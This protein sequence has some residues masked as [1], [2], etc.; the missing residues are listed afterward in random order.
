LENVDYPF[1]PPK[2]NGIKD[3]KDLIGK[4]IA[5]SFP[6]CTRKYFNTIDPKETTSIFS[7]S[8][9]VEVSCTLGLSDAIVDLIETGET[10]RAAGL[11]E[12]QTILE[13]EAVF[14]VN[15]NSKFKDLAQKISKRLTGVLT[16]QNFVMVEYN[17]Q[18]KSLDEAKKITPGKT[19]PTISP[20][21]NPDWISIKV[22]IPKSQSNKIL[23]ELVDIGAKDI[24]VT[25]IQN[26]RTD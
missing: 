1:K 13:T 21:D 16:S 10:M 12:L 11:E 22:M 15:P 9:S 23:D 18:R 5:T 17:I 3:V 19:S 4:R 2:K 24:V 14:I 20:L 25:T 8:G 7:V 6:C 26:C